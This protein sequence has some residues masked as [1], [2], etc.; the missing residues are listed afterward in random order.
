MPFYFFFRNSFIVFITS[1]QNTEDW[2]KQW[3]HRTSWNCYR[4]TYIEFHCLWLGFLL[5]SWKKCESKFKRWSKSWACAF[6]RWARKV[7]WMN[8]NRENRKHQYLRTRSSVTEKESSDG[9][10]KN[11]EAET[12]KYCWALLVLIAL[13]VGY[14]C[15]IE[16]RFDKLLYYGMQVYYT[17]DFFNICVVSLCFCS[18][19]W[20]TFID[21]CSH[22]HSVWNEKIK[23]KGDP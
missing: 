10:C 17:D 3:M 8:P 16:G 12:N 21:W 15:E 11:R 22:D 9:K 6:G 19:Y 13:L 18:I 20:K 23:R 1:L 7:N 4:W 5:V 14:E 2:K